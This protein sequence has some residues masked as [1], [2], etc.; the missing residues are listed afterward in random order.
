MH[1]L[2]PEFENYLSKISPPPHPILAEMESFARERDF[3]I[4]GPLVGRFLYQLVR[5]IQAKRVFELGSGFGYSAFWIAMALPEDGTLICTE[6]SRNNVDL[7][8][9]FLERGGLAQKVD[10]RVGDAVRIFAESEGSFDFVFNDVD[11]HQYPQV[12]DLVVPRIKPGGFFV[13]DNLLWHG[14]VFSEADDE[15][16]VGVREFT[17]RIFSEP[18]LWSTIIPLR[19]GLGVCLK[20]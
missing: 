3:P 13:S 7:G 1:A 15:D 9:E 11:K 8:V 4:V 2:Q 16:T 20:L 5:A 17:R 6:A 14:K 12:F 10:F 18:G 19:D